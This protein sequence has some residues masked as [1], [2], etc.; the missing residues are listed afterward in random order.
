MTQ[1]ER[2]QQEMMEMVAEFIL[3]FRQRF[4]DGL[5]VTIKPIN[6]KRRWVK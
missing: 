6:R 1:E 4:G 2:E 3:K 5:K